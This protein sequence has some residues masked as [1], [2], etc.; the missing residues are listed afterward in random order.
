[1]PL[2]GIL[3]NP[4]LKPVSAGLRQWPPG[5]RLSLLP[6]RG[7]CVRTR[8][9]SCLRSCAV[10]GLVLALL[11]TA[12]LHLSASR[13]AAQAGATT[14][15]IRGTVRDP[16][17]DPLRGA[18][19][20]AQ[21]RET[22][23][24]TRVE[25]SAS[26]TFVRPLLPPGTY[27]LTVTAPTLGFST[28]RIQGVTLRVGETL[29]L[30]IDLRLV[31]TET[32]TVVSELPSTLDTADV[33]SSQRMR[34]DVV[35]G[36]PSNGRN[37]M[38]MTLLT[39]GTAISQG[40]DGDELNISGQRGIFNNFIVDGADFNNP[41][42]G[43]QR[44]G[45]RPAFTFNQ[46][47]IEELVVVN[48]GA[49]AEFGRSAGG[50]VNVITKSGTNEVHGTA[51]YFGQWDEI[52]APFPAMRGG[53][54]PDFYRN[55]VGATLGGPVA[56]DRVFYFLAYDQQAGAETKQT[57]RRVA[58]P[59][60]L[61]MLDD[62]LQRRW[63]GLFD[64]EFGPI[65][66]T[67]SARALLTKLDLNIDDR[68]QASVKYNYTW[69]EQ[70]N[71]TFDVDSWGASANGIEGDLSHA[72]NGSL[73]SLL[74]NAMSNEFR[75]Q[76]ARE[77]R[78]R[79]YEGPLVPGARLPGPPQFAE[80]GG[81]PFPDIAMDFADGFRIG[82][83]F[84]L[85]IKPAFDTRLQVVDN[86]SFATGSHLIKA[87]AEYNRTSVEQQFVGFANS[88][89]VFDSVP[90]FVGFVTHGDSYVTCTDG[91]ASAIGACPPGSAVSGPV[92]LYLQSATVSGVPAERLGHQSFRVHEMGLFVQDS[93]QP[94]KRVTLDLGLRWDG[95]WH[96]DVF[97]EPADAFFAPYLDDP[98]FPSDG[99]IPDDLDNLQ[100]RLGL[101]WDLAGDGRTVLRANAGS[102]V[103]RIPMLVFAQHRSTNGA[104]QQ[105]LFRS[106]AASGL[107][108]VP[109]IDR[110][111]DASEAAPF[112]PDIHVADRNLELPRTWSSRVGLERDLG[113][114]IAANVGYIQARTDY[115]FRFVNR[116]DAAFGTPFGIGTHPSG[117]GINTLTVAESSARSRYHAL[118]AG[119]RGR[120]NIRGRPLAFEASYTLAFD[121]SDD[122]NERDPFVFRYAH[123]GNLEPEFG[124][125]DRDRRH[126]VS[127]YFLTTLGW[128]IQLSH[129]VRYLS[130]SP[131]SERCSDP[132]AR[133]AQPSDR[134]CVDGSILRRNTLRRQ[135]DFVTWDLRLSRRFSIRDHAFFEPVFEAFNLTNAD[136]FVDPAVG[137]LLFNFDGSLRSGL[138]DTRRAQ[139]GLRVQF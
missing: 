88:R 132:G 89:Y 26:G 110:Q 22:D 57:N 75:V 20:A 17:G 35:Y 128:G 16:A 116:N 76:V 42:F 15:V 80:L 93:W 36:L 46:D 39:P 82:L 130:P 56:R 135:N 98:R 134:I 14:G 117:G 54:R 90:G 119:V 85:P 84:F 62:F 127:G 7:R 126:Q 139:V 18:V 34:E 52:A 33:T 103:A 43:E 106:S 95:T 65:R 3:Y 61:R 123:A 77:D 58:N 1:M 122:D 67:D 5:P 4:A 114:G 104:F 73:R 78:P 72:V 55:Q 129:I 71:G 32:V 48:Q 50:F 2:G 69:S 27:D 137:S 121:R 120:G 53:G 63:P 81:R 125:S 83:P 74:T 6:P 64:D 40:P 41:F 51:H 108:P 21:H 79:W 9:A 11:G 12:L 101:A 113:Q 47:A 94:H 124:W 31:A 133:A 28:E 107:G 49:T 8:V 86:V 30:A 25:T 118:V 68:H 138:G 109:A 60:N 10:R 115:L 29:D 111:L 99:R 102:Y 37:F 100:P 66:R 45:Q 92:L 24:Q 23:L 38:N 105:T 96:P 59:E 91:S 136:N 112:L 19:V 97:I 44:G 13:L 87:G 70:V 131:V